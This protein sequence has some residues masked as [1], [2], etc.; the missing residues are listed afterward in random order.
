MRRSHDISSWGLLQQWVH[1]VAVSPL[2]PVAGI[3]KGSSWSGGLRDFAVV[4]VGVA[5]VGGDMGG[6][7][8]SVMAD[9]AGYC[10]EHGSVVI[11]PRSAGGN[12]C[13]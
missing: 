6:W 10:S 13:G 3:V 7:L 2:I 12:S 5:A 4:A 8:V 9:H 1:A 11:W